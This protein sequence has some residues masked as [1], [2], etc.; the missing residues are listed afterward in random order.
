MLLTCQF[1]SLSDNYITWNNGGIDFR[2]KCQKFSFHFYHC[3]S[4]VPICKS[5]WKLFPFP[6]FIFEC[7]KLL[8]RPELEVHVYTKLANRKYGK[9]WGTHCSSLS[10]LLNFWTKRKL[11]VA[12]EKV[13]FFLKLVAVWNVAFLLLFGI[14]RESATSQKKKPLK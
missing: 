6:K 7:C 13:H 5:N 10:T 4:V 1:C 11:D 3:K 14:I 8:L 12:F 2:Q 9:W